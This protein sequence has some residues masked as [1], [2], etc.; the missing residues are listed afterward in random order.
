MIRPPPRC[1]SAATFVAALAL[2]S[3]HR[4][5]AQPAA[6]DPT[7]AC[8]DAHVAAQ[9][10][11]RAGR[12]LLAR[13]Q[14]LVCSQSGCPEVLVAECTEIRAKLDGATPSVVFAVKDERGADVVMARVFDGDRLLV[15]RLDG[16]AVEVDPGEHRFRVELEGEPPRIETVLLREGER[17]RRVTFG[18]TEGSTLGGGTRPTANGSTLGTSPAFWILGAAGVAGLGL[19]AGLGGAGLAQRGELE[20]L[21]CKPNCPA[22]EV[23]AM[24]RLLLGADVSL[25]FGLASLVAATIVF[26]VAGDEAT[27][28]RAAA[29]SDALLL[30]WVT[31]W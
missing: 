10:E 9:R 18:S 22:D 7:A 11:Q 8:I 25:G 24:R 23:D 28:V 6:S 19:F 30:E 12:L 2:A 16:K 29:R 5:V 14:A 13:E 1:R 21:A 4:V 26:F 3:G 17:L 15:E 31:A 20:E 27:T